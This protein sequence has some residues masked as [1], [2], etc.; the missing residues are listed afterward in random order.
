MK[1]AETIIQQISKLEQELYRNYTSEEIKTAIEKCEN[2]ELIPIKC[3]DLV[4]VI[5]E[6]VC[7]DISL[8]EFIGE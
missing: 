7:S 8:N 6:D 2:E 5:Y 4:S 1:K 3:D